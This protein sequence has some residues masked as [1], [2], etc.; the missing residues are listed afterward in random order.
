[1][2]S[3]AQRNHRHLVQHLTSSVTELEV[4]LIS[5]VSPLGCKDALNRV[6][7]FQLKFEDY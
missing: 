7:E 3:Q 2:S 4:G 6:P 5:S 1:M